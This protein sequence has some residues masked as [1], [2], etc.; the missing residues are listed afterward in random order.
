M[1]ISFLVVLDGAGRLGLLGVDGMT[2]HHVGAAGPLAQVDHPATLAAERKLGIFAQHQRLAGGTTQ[3]E[4]AFT[5]HRPIGR[6]L[7]QM[8]ADQS[9]ISNLRVSA[10]ICGSNQFC[11]QVVIVCL[12]DL[13]GIELAGLDLLMRAEI[14]DEHLA[15]DLGR[16]HWGSAFP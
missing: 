10:C 12:G 9:W 7:T 15:V 3:A 8:N 4:Q 13:A 16:V 6:R 2:A 14:V 11:H 5:G 1:G